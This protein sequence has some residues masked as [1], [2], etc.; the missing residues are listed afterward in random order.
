[1]TTKSLLFLLGKVLI[2]FSLRLETESM[3]LLSKAVLT[4]LIERKSNETTTSL[5]KKK[6]WDRGHG[7]RGIS[8]WSNQETY[9]L[10]HFSEGLK[11]PEKWCT[12]F[13]EFR[14]EYVD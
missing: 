4:H 12:K 1:M 7:K 5:N 8:S 3:Q 14:D 13:V 2:D 11:K 6:N 10:L 9:D